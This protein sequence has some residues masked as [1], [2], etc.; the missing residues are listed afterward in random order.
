L[1][2]GLEKAETVAREVNSE[3]D[4]SL[5]AS[6]SIL[7]VTRKWAPAIGG[8]ETYSYELTQALKLRAPTQVLAL[9]GRDN[10]L[11]PKISSL[12]AFAVS[13]ITR[14]L[15]Q[16]Q[17]ADVVH[18][19]DMAIWPLGLAARLR[20][21]KSRIVLSAHGTDVSYPRRGGIR[22][23]AYGLYLRLG[24]KLL[25]NAKVIANSEATGNA[26]AENGWKN[27]DVIPLATDM[28]G[29]EPTGSHGP[30]ILFAGRLIEL[31][32]CAWFIHNVLPL[33]PN[34]IRLKVAGTVWDENECQAL[35]HPRVD[36]LGHLQKVALI[37]AYREALCVIVP[38]IKLVSGQF[39]GFGLV[40]VEAAA[41]GG[42]VLASRTGGLIHAVEDGVTGLLLPPANPQ[43]W[44][45]T[46][47]DIGH[48][49]DARRRAFLEKSMTYC[50]SYYCWDRVADD[51]YRL[52]FPLTG[53]A[54]PDHRA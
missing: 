41:V 24:A 16:R 49:T 34:P 8:M 25:H 44:A 36:Y 53:G 7:F 39:E 1:H 3:H 37:D 28:A 15:L 22:G 29:P 14:L 17:P 40:A 54:H 45:R 51:T 6:V 9:P 46:I 10:G 50:R 20:S 43:A 21:R 18:I 47:S 48:W 35:N 52:Y 19:G 31:K 30:D 42:L 38:N 32:G 13:T 11:P 33:V 26:A 5:A 12:F 27:I 4:K 2:S 23:G